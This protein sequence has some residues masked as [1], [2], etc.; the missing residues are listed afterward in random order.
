MSISEIVDVC[1]KPAIIE[2]RDM[3]AAAQPGIAALI[4]P[5]D[6]SAKMGITFESLARAARTDAHDLAANPTL[7]AWQL[8]LRKVGDLWDDLAAAFGGEE[9]ARLFLTLHRPELLNQTPLYYLERGEPE[10][11]QSL[12]DAM[13]EMLP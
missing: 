1:Q 13:R 4:D 3:S 9:N 11:V 5:I 8:R 7:I 10:I 2:G 12:V 6:L